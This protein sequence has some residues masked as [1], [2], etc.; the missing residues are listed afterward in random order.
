MVQQ[1]QGLRKEII[2]KAGRLYELSGELRTKSRRF[3]ADE[4]TSNYIMFANAHLR[5]AGAL[6]QGIRR[7]ASTDRVLEV[8]QAERDEARRRDETER[9]WR[10]A[11]QK[12]KA[13]N[14][15]VLTS[16]DAFDE[17]Y[18]DVVAEEVSN[19]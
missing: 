13:S 16:D 19:A 10:E 3:L 4:G 17:I 12:T 5:L 18:G 1:I 14:D 6:T 15:L 9:E 11:R 7:T 8:G 2:A